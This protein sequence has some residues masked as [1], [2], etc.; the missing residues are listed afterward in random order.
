MPYSKDPARKKILVN[1]ARIKYWKVNDPTP[2]LY[3]YGY[4]CKQSHM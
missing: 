1:R 2:E 4:F 3:K